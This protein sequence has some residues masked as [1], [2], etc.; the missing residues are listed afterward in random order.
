MPFDG[1]LP[2]PAAIPIWSQYVDFLKW[3]LDG[4]AQ[5]VGNGG[6]AIVIFTI[7]VRT[8][9]LPITV[10]S[11]RSMK[12]MQD[13]QPKIKELQKKYKGDR[14]KIQQETMAL[15]Q[16]YGV[17]PIAGCLPALLQLPIFFGVY[18]AILALSKSDTGVWHESFLWLHSL[19]EPDPWH[20]LPILAG[21]FQLMQ[22]FMSRP[23]GQGKVTDPQQAMM[24]TMMNIMPI[25]VVLFGWGFAAGA[26]IY[27]V[28]QS[29]Y[30]IIQQWFITGWGKL[31]DYVPNLPE[32]PEHR[33][34]GYHPPK[35][36]DELANLP[37]KKKGFFG[38]W[39]EKQMHAAQQM[40]ED[41]KAAPAGAGASA[42]AD[43]SP[44]SDQPRAA[45]PRRSPNAHIRATHPRAGCWPSRRNALRQDADSALDADIV[46]EDVQSADISA[47]GA[48]KPTPRR[49]R[50]A[51]K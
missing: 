5:A 1:A 44:T 50:R 10:R 49:N 23:A 28:T 16:T 41:R 31:N 30:G 21:I 18:R 14:M 3:V 7:I 26:V 39:W 13:I 29:L 20:I 22:T 46:A 40:Q 48:A 6:L 51:K 19:K 27:W 34:L 38:T 36:L 17:N 8:L 43:S 33:R 2:F 37:P 35:D 4:I 47:N 42:S 24:N 15:Y 32:L 11:I 9:I 45:H 25:T 12:A